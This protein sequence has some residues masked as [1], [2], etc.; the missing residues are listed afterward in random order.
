MEAEYKEAIETQLEMT[1]YVLQDDR[2]VKANA[3]FAD[4]QYDALMGTGKFGHA[5][6]IT[7]IA[8]ILGRK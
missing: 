8:A 4:M 3:K 7:I 1:E 5:D 2:A 6:C